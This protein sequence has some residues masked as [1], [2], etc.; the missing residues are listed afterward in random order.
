MFIDTFSHKLQVHATS[1]W[2]E[3]PNTNILLKELYEPVHKT[4]TV[5]YICS[6]LS[7]P[8]GVHS[9]IRL[10]ANSEHMISSWQF[11]F[12][13]ALTS[14][15]RISGIYTQNSRQQ[16]CMSLNC[17]P[18][19]VTILELKKQVQYF[20]WMTVYV[21]MFILKLPFTVSCT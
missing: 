14:V 6:F 12:T 16:T 1:H 18:C 11:F 15:F 17:Q 9:N 13:C 20:L 10:S 7:H 3:V 19:V 4:L 2:Y 21:C 8:A 5:L